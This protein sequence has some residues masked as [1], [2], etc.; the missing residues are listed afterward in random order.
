MYSHYDNEPFRAGGT[1]QASRTKR[2][3]FLAVAS[4][5]VLVCVSGLAMWRMRQ[6]Q[7]LSVQSGSMAP[8]VQVGDAVV[9][10]RVDI[11]DL[12]AGDVI[13]FRSPADI[14]VVVTHRIVQIDSV[15]EDSKSSKD[16]RSAITTRGDN[17]VTPD[18]P[19]N[20]Q[21]IIGRAV[22]HIPNLGFGIDFIHSTA[23]LV[24]GV[25]LPAA[26]MAAIELKRLTRYYGPVYRHAVARSSL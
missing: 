20:P 8:L 22:G 9:V 14:S 7:I 17:N 2:W 11:A 19:L 25:Y 21:L 10:E 26:I 15:G 18:L 3:L 23:G 16:V 24:I 5:L 6:I 4:V 13:S 12:A 1:H